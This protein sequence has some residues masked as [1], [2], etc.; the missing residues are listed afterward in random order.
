ML[1]LSQTQFH[2][3]TAINIDVSFP[4]LKLF[5]VAYSYCNGKDKIE[6]NILSDDNVGLYMFYLLKN[7][8]NYIDHAA[9]NI[10]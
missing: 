6:Y 5:N 3:S 1:N 8:F 4:S 7:I 10:S 2:F 9:R